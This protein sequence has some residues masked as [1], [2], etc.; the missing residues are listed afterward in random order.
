MPVTVAATL[1]HTI[2]FV[3]E[4][5]NQLEKTIDGRLTETGP[6]R[7]IRTFH[8]QAQVGSGITRPK[9]ATRP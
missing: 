4:S 1:M 3:D 9:P 6:V 7:A 8:W 2:L 5:T